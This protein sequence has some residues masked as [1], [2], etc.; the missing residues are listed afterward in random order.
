MIPQQ[1]SIYAR[2]LYCG[3][4]DHNLIPNRDTQCYNEIKDEPTL[5]SI[6]CVAYA[7]GAVPDYRLDGIHRMKD[8]SLRAKT[9]VCAYKHGMPFDYDDHIFGHFCETEYTRLLLSAYYQNALIPNYDLHRIHDIQE[10]VNRFP[11]LSLGYKKGMVMDYKTH[12]VGDLPIN[13][14]LP[15]ALYKYPR[16]EVLIAAYKSG[17]NV[18]WISH[19]LYL[20]RL[21]AK[22]TIRRELTQCCMSDDE[23]DLFQRIKMRHNL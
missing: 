18:D 12:R 3:Y 5:S 10:S 15:G 23:F 21:E 8:D 20:L 14:Y 2:S 19:E 17:N 6:L 16:E 22:A 1:E 9:L 4:K 7:Y 13:N 11:I